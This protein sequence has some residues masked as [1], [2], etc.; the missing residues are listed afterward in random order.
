MTDLR[1]DIAIVGAGPVGL[2]LALALAQRRR[3]LRLT[4]V[5]AR[6]P[7]DA[8]RDPRTLA[9]SWG[10]CLTLQRL[11]VWTQLAPRATAI[12]TVHVS[13]AG[14]F[15]RT[16]LHAHEEGVPALGYVVRAGELARALGDA[17][18]E[19]ADL[20]DWQY[21]QLARPG[22]ARTQEVSLRL[23]PAKDD[24][25]AP[26]WLH[27]R[28]AACAEGG[29]DS[30]VGARTRDYH[31]SAIIGEIT[32]AGGHGNQAWERFTPAG[33]LALL[34]HGDGHA[35]VHVVAPADVP[36]LCAL[37]GDAYCAELQKLIGGR[38]H[39]TGIGPRH[40]FPLGLRWRREPVGRR[41]VWLGNAAQTLHPVAGQGFNLS[42][43][44]VWALVELI[45][46]RPHDPGAAE[47]LADYREARKTDR[48]ATIALTDRLVRI[49]S[50]DFAP[51]RHARGLALAALDI[52]PP[53]R[54]ALARQFMFGRRS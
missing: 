13:H 1:T 14:G 2:A 18:V 25:A 32:V 52:T 42:L 26:T 38:V 36:A 46:A 5:D 45:A 3:G 10:T 49:F 17:L 54:S 8:T 47:L 19:H 53:L 33:P 50:N 7:G 12:T 20:I 34:P 9:L 35:L 31:Q 40:V 41:T 39:I 29:L 37:D 23:S 4:L 48:A 44:D 51:L 22:L 15:G 16:V 21:H 43:R 30:A 27:A 28:L 6:G 11:G 24:E